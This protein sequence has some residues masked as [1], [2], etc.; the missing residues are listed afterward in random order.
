[1]AP[2][3]VAPVLDLC[4]EQGRILHGLISKL[5]PGAE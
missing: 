4:D 1:V 3:Q 5:E 2:A